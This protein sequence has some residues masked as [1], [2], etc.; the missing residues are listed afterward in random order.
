[1]DAAEGTFDFAVARYVDVV[2]RHQRRVRHEADPGF[3]SHRSAA[4]GAG[5]VD[6]DAAIGIDV[7]V[8]IFPGPRWVEVGNLDDGGA[9]RFLVVYDMDAI[10]SPR[11][12]V[13]IGVIKLLA[14]GVADAVE[15]RV[16]A[17]VQGIG[18]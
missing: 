9:R 2:L 15:N 3:E 16:A 13:A 8:A 12:R 7:G 4:I 18:D 1:M 5:R 17:A 10:I 14:Y 6:D 11:H